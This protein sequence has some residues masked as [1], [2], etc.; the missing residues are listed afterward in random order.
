MSDDRKQSL[1]IVA[2]EGRDT[3]D[4]VYDVLHDAGKDTISIKSA[5]TVQRKDDGKL[6]LDH[7]RRVT[8]WKGLFG[9]GA[10]GLVL[11]GPGGALA[12]AGIGALI[13][14]TR[15]GGRQDAKEFLDDKLGPDDSA[16]VILVNDADWATVDK[17]IGSYGGV[18]LKVELTPEAEQQIAALAA[19]EEVAEKLQEE[20]EVVEQDVDDEDA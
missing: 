17:A 7:K 4:E 19:D 8:F 3:A 9:G 16:L 20:V 14:S 5:A 15:A 18:D 13:G 1:F 11:A 6:K 10:I 12:G 2:Y